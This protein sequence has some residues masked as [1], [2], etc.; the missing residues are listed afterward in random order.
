MHA[1]D[2]TSRGLDSGHKMLMAGLATQLAMAQKTG[3]DVMH[4]Y[5]HDLL[6]AIEKI[7][8]EA[9][10]K[11]VTMYDNHVAEHVNNNLLPFYNERIIPVYN[12]RIYPVYNENILPV[13][14]EHVSPAVKTIESEVSVA[15]QKSQEGVQLAR[16]K[17]ALLVE[18]TST[19]V[20]ELIDE[21]DR[22]D[23]SML[24]Q[25]LYQ[26]LDHASRDGEWAVE[27]LFR[28]LLIIVAILCRSLIFRILGYV[29]SWIWFFCPLRLFVRAR[30]K[31][32][33]KNDTKGVKSKTNGR[34]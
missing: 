27:K 34:G 25:W 8:R 32:G 33:T 18:E 29:L 24:P 21:T 12:E 10:T 15:I 13:Y 30:P 1:L 7:V 5:E 14:M 20:L 19:A 3:T 23:K 11:A 17:S 28:G 26:I 4:Y 22:V 16:E 9:M 31:E 6:P 2:S